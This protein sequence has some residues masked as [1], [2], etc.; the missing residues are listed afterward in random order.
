MNCEFSQLVSSIFCSVCSWAY[1]VMCITFHQARNDYETAYLKVLKKNFNSEFFRLGNVGHIFLIKET[2]KGRCY[3]FYY[4][5]H[6]YF[7]QKKKLFWLFLL[8]IKDFVYFP[9]SGLAK[10]SYPCTCHHLLPT[11]WPAR[12]S[13][14]F[15]STICSFLFALNNLVFVHSFELADNHK[16][17]NSET[18]SAL[19]LYPWPMSNLNSICWKCCVISC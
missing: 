1:F 6:S 9:E 15:V 14:C 12:S 11:Y 19:T 3:Y 18:N 5:W 17:L 10:Y 13:I 4:C 8:K 16:G 7:K 2:K